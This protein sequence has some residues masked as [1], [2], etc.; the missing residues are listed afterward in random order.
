MSQGKSGRAPEQAASPTSFSARRCIGSASSV[1]SRRCAR[2][3]DRK[4]DIVG[5]ASKSSLLSSNTPIQLRCTEGPLCRTPNQRLK[6]GYG[7]KMPIPAHNPKGRNG[8]QVDLKQIV[9]GVRNRTLGRSFRYSGLFQ[10]CWQ[11]FHHVSRIPPSPLREI[12]VL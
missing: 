11:L 5:M 3:V 9:S 8:L 7:P 6:V 2:R 1:P 10:N 12:C 4:A